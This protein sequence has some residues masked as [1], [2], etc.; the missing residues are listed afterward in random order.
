MKKNKLD[1]YY[2]QI[3]EKLERKSKQPLFARK[4]I[5]IDYKK[6]SKRVFLGNKK[7]RENLVKSLYAGDIY[8][9]KNVFSK[10]F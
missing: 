9:L 8:L 7:V 2:K 5:K 1:N 3:W 6:F 4:L 10:Q